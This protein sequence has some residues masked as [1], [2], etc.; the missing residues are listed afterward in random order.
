MTAPA[1]PNTVRSAPLTRGSTVYGPVRKPAGDW[2]AATVAFLTIVAFLA[3]RADDFPAP[4]NSEQDTSATPLSAA[5]AA[6]TMQV[7]EGFRVDVFAAEPD[8]QNPIAMSWDGRGRLW[9]AENMTYAG[10]PAR[11]EERLRDRV[12][13]FE[14]A[15]G[16]G[17]AERHRVFVDGLRQLTG[18]EVAPGGVWLM[19]PPHLL[20]LPD[21]DGDDR[22]DGPPRVMLDGFD[23]ASESYHNFANGLR[24]GPDG[25]LY[26]RCGGS[27]PGLIGPPGTAP[28]RRV[29][30][31]GGIWR[32]APQTGRFEVVLHGTTNPWGHDWNDYGDGFCINTVT[33]HLWQMIPG[34]HYPFNGR[35]DPNPYVFEPI[36]T[37]ADHFHFDTGAGW[38]KSRDGA[39]NDL[40]GGHAHSGLMIYLGDD[41]PPEYRGRLFTW[42]MH[43][44]R[45]NQELL[46]REGSGYVGRHGRDTFISG[47]PFFRGIELAYGPDGSVMAIDWSDTGECHERTGVHR[48][49]GRIFRIAHGDPPRRSAV[50]LSRLP[51]T[52]IA[53]LTTHV[54]EWF[55][56]QARL[57]LAARAAANPASVADA[58]PILRRCAAAAD[59]VTACRGVL[60]LHACGR[61]SVA[62]RIALLSH[63]DEH[64]RAWGVR[65]L[66]DPWPIDGVPGPPALSPTD[67]A[68]VAADSERLAPEFLRLAAHD[69]S[70][71]VRLAIASALQRMPVARRADLAAALMARVEDAA[72]HNLP[73]L[74]WY[75]LMP[76][77]EA[78]PER[79]AD[80]ALGSTWPKTRRLVAR[81]LAGL[82]DRHPE[83]VDRLVA[84]AAT[85]SDASLRADVVSGIADGLAGWRRAPQPVAWEAMVAAAGRGDEPLATTIRDLSAVFGDGR[86]LGE[87]RRLVL[88]ERAAADVRRSAL[89]SLVRQGDDGLRELCLGLLGDRRFNVVAAEGLA[90]GDDPETARALVATYGRFR[91][92]D[93]PRLIAVLTSRPSFARALVE[94]VAAGRI[95]RDDVGSYD[96]RQLRGLGDPA[97]D[98]AVESIWGRVRDTPEQRRDQIAALKTALTPAA[99]AAADLPHGRQLFDRSCGRCHRLFGAGENV[100][101]DLTGGNRTNLD[102]LLENIVDPS[103]AVAREYR[104][105]VVTFAD[106]RVLGGLVTS[107]NDRTLTLVTPTETHV[108]SLADV[109]DVTLTAQSPMPDGML[110]QLPTDAIRDLIGYL[111]QPAQVP[112][113]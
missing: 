56:R 96:V 48:T 45:A 20:F 18:L 113:P 110:D 17:R 112:L 93:R 25:W 97:V 13:V 100:G 98:A 89:E 40:G 74:V 77:V 103:G 29:R 4:F 37:H 21:A 49:S 32:Y 1:H 71:L 36:A 95:P 81:R 107:R 54:N 106:G 72:D 104:M 67:A 38:Q 33:G 6:A 39:A 69:A 87:I 61:L 90:R 2:P 88:D 30:L 64:L 7:P 84:G 79:A 3:A 66:C 22:P 11:I 55:V 41:W 9:I 12:V 58:E 27:C 51:I 59:P 14:D 35:L 76:V 102:Y 63:P 70:G 44:R 62:D 5:E 109:D 68:A 46:Q 108:L 16:D 82:I 24:F 91:A 8:V 28:E 85:T 23:V 99:L 101:P 52:A 31:E 15:D 73:L 94:A 50:D 83:A 43:G 78:F 105:S 10:G 65:L 47:D 92:P 111:M 75:G 42:N 19:C 60:A 53:E 86:A 34:A 80:L 26:G 57:Q